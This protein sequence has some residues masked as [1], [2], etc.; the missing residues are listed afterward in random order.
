MKIITN[1]EVTDN[2]DEYFQ[3]YI[4]V[5]NELYEEQ[6]PKLFRMHTKPIGL[7]QNT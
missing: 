3:T 7:H 5:L 4:K 1:I 6:T 2:D